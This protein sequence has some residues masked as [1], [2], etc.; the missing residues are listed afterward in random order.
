MDMALDDIIASKGG[1]GGGRGRGRGGRGRGDARRDQRFR[2]NMNTFKSNRQ[3]AF[4]ARRTNTS[5]SAQKNRNRYDEGADSKD[6]WEHDLFQDEGEEEEGEE[7]GEEEVEMGETRS[8]SFR[9]GRGR[10]RGRGSGRGRFGR[11]GVQTGAKIHVSNLQGSVG[12]QNLKEV[13]ENLGAKVLKTSIHYDASGR[14]DGTG[15]I[16]LPTRSE[17]LSF[18]TKY[19]GVEIDGKPMTLT[20]LTGGSVNRLASSISITTRR[21]RGRGRR[22]FGE[23]RLGLKSFTR[24]RGN[25][26]RNFLRRV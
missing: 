10:G 9:G 12:E 23:R 18:I 1:R 21:G 25:P 15:E 16:T 19:N 7:E 8:S 6:V 5:F 2:R 24:N 4:N 13:F 17:A 11:S 20:L 22:L 26:S 14:S 3:N